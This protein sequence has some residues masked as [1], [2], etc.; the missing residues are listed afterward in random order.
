MAPSGPNATDNASVAGPGSLLAPNDKWIPVTWMPHTNLSQTSHVSVKIRSVQVTRKRSYGFS[1][2]NRGES[3]NPADL[4]DD[5]GEEEDEWRVRVTL[6]HGGG[7][8]LENMCSHLS[9]SSQT[10]AASV[11]PRSYVSSTN[12]ESTFHIIPRVSGSTHECHWE[13]VVHLAMRWRDVPRDSYFLFEVLDWDNSVVCG[14]CKITRN[15]LLSA[16]HTSVLQITDLSSF[17]STVFQVWKASDR[18]TT[19]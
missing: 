17:S 1:S 15:R 10:P 13:N 2:I 11:E 7:N 14:S 8:V 18:I 4:N 9:L 12:L 19:G 3:Q 5:E 6:C 16:P